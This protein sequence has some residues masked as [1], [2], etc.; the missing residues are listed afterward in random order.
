MAKIFTIWRFDTPNR[1]VFI[2]KQVKQL[3]KGK[4]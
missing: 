1:Y 2:N 3:K 4:K